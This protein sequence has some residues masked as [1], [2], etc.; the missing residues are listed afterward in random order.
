MKRSSCGGNSPFYKHLVLTETS[1]SDS[2]SLHDY[3]QLANV[4][5][6]QSSSLKEPLDPDYC[7]DDNDQVPSVSQLASTQECSHGDESDPLPSFSQLSSS[8][9]QQVNDS[10]PCRIGD[11]LTSLINTSAGDSDDATGTPPHQSRMALNLTFSSSSLDPACKDDSHDTIHLS[12]LTQNTASQ[13]VLKKDSDS[14][15]SP[16][17]L[18]FFS[19]EL[20]SSDHYQVLNVLSSPDIHISLSP[21]TLL[22]KAKDNEFLF[23]QNQSTLKEELNNLMEKT[24]INTLVETIL[25]NDLLSK[26]ITTQLLQKAHKEFKSSVSKSILRTTKKNS[27]DR[28]YLLSLTPKAL[29]EEFRDNSPQAFD[30]LCRGLF[31]LSDSNKVFESQ[32]LMNNTSLL[33]STICKLNNRKATGFALLLTNA[34]RDGGMREDTIKLFSCLVHPRTSQKYDRRVLAKDWDLELRQSLEEEKSYFKT[35]QMEELKLR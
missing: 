27:C 12:R 31:G 20:L 24:N 14:F 3:P 8:D 32:H 30:L 19:S 33:F 21:E 11:F 34:A 10:S 28:R 4:C 17:E 5:V 26:E 23:K 29:C 1:D 18:N 15:S 16:H 7:S 6:S 22:D 13:D 9:S 35:L 2:E 25:D